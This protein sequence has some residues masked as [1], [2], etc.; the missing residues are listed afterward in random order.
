MSRTRAGAAIVTHFRVEARV[1]AVL[2]DRRRVKVDPADH[3]PVRTGVLSAR[4]RSLRST[5]STSL[6][7]SASRG[8]AGRT[9]CASLLRTHGTARGGA[10]PAAS[11]TTNQRAR[12]NGARHP[13]LQ[14]VK[15]DVEANGALAD[16]LGVQGVPTLLLFNGGRCVERLVGKVFY[17]ALER[18]VRRHM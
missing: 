13:G 12:A 6:I 10:G 17:V 7:D 14:V 16:E 4:R 9:V 3:F 5:T 1:G 15:V 2:F 11:R 18:A 8:K